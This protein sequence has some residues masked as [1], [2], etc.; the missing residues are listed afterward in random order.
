MTALRANLHDAD[1]DAKLAAGQALYKIHKDLAPRF[2]GG[3]AAR[4]RGVPPTSEELQV[5]RA[6]LSESEFTCVRG[7]DYA[8][9]AS[10]DTSDAI[11]NSLIAA[12]RQPQPLA[13][14]A[15]VALG[16]IGGKSDIYQ[17]IGLRAPSVNDRIRVMQ[18]LMQLGQEGEGAVKALIGKLTD[19]NPSLR[20][21]AIQALD[22]MGGSARPAGSAL[23]QVMQTDSLR[24]NRVIAAVALGLIVEE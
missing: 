20:R 11:F 17:L 8:A 3:L 7:G 1:L 6:D 13:T 9:A 19:E 12:Q 24:D 14:Q 5:V 22:S 15:R 23:I 16:M 18:T 21:A 10:G 2:P 4:L